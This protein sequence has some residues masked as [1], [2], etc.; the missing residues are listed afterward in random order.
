MF[1]KKQLFSMVV[2]ALMFGKH[3]AAQ[4]NTAQNSTVCFDNNFQ[5]YKSLSGDN[6]FAFSQDLGK[7]GD[8]VKEMAKKCDLT[9]D[10]VP[11]PQFCGE[12]TEL[13]GYV[14][15]DKPYPGTSMISSKKEGPAYDC[16]E[17][18][19]DDYVS[20][21]KLNIWLGPVI[22][23]TLPITV[24]IAILLSAA[25]SLIIIGPPAACGWLLFHIVRMTL[26][27]LHD[28][29]ALAQQP[30]LLDMG[31]NTSSSCN[32]FGNCCPNTVRGYQEVD[33]DND[34]CNDAVD[35]PNENRSYQNSL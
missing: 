11:P 9:F 20:N 13:F 34:D 24:T 3:N 7:F 12:S 26:R 23:F 22:L 8:P 5:V 29:M 19:S 27:Y 14:F 4:N 32:P 21:A 2:T 18:F 1:T 10:E 25:I 15:A 6:S 33:G 16:I 28:E 30:Q 17:K 31:D 35:N